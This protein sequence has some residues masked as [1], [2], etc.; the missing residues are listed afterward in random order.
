MWTGQGT[1]TGDRRGWT[2]GCSGSPRGN[3]SLLPTALTQLSSLWAP[4]G[5]WSA[6]STKVPT[7][8]V[9]TVIARVRRMIQSPHHVVAATARGVTSVTSWVIAQFGVEAALRVP[10]VASVSLGDGRH[11][12]GRH[13][14]VV[15]QGADGAEVKEVG[16]EA[17]LCVQPRSPS[18]RRSSG[19]G[20]SRPLRSDWRTPPPG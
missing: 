16:A 3:L 2:G 1:P 18:H 12:G 14:G 13:S 7:H 5:Q 10:G 17:V 9:R 11:A 19:C 6:K 15:R 20:R 4:V 8:L